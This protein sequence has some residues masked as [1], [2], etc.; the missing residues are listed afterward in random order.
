MNL[1]FS[2]ADALVA[3]SRLLEASGLLEENTNQQ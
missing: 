2:K 3:Y 1:I